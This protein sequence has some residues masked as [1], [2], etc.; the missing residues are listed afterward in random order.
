MPL[1]KASLPGGL[2]WFSQMLGSTVGSTRNSLLEGA[3]VS[4]VA[5]IPF[6]CNCNIDKFSL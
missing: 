3:L 1:G 5:I 6:G 4:S 2:H